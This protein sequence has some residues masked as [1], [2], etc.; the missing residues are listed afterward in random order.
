MSSIL[1][2]FYT[3]ILISLLKSISAGIIVADN[4][5][6]CHE[7]CNVV[8]LADSAISGKNFTDLKPI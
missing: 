8:L 2:F 7:A 1:A 6:Y 5:S 3:V 4:F